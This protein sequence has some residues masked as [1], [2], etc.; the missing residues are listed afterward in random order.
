MKKNTYT[1]Q[2]VNTYLRNKYNVI[3]KLHLDDNDLFDISLTATTKNNS[4]STYTCKHNFTYN[5]DKICIEIGTK[6]NDN[7]IPSGLSSVM[8]DF[9]ILTFND[10]RSFYLIRRDKVLKWA[11]SIKYC[12]IDK[13]TSWQSTQSGEFMLTLFDRPTFLAK[14]QKI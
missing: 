9:I 5:N 1:I 10:D 6:I 7:I 3:T 4:V 2:R 8:S 14:C 12:G 13:Y 11:N